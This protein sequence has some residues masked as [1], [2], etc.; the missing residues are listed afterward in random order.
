MISNIRLSRSP[1]FSDTLR[2]EFPELGV[3]YV[4]VKFSANYDTSEKQFSLE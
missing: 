3:F 4:L 1:K 2:F